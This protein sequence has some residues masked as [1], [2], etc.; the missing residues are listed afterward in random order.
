MFHSFALVSAV[1]CVHR[2]R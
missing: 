2:T 1:W